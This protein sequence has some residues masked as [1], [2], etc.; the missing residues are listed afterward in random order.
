[1]YLRLKVVHSTEKTIIGQNLWF[2]FDSILSAY[3]DKLTFSEID[4]FHFFDVF[5]AKMSQEKLK[6]IIGLQ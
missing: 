4:K 1:M 2:L 3:S 5:E 6:S